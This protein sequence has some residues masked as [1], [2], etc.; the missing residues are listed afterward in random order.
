M[1][2]ARQD[3]VQSL[4]PTSGTRGAREEAAATR[5]EGRK[6]I[7]PE[8]RR[9]KALYVEWHTQLARRATGLVSTQ[10][11]LLGRGLK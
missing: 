6:D 11:S 2:S 5:T 1:Y 9:A 4:E 10:L 3:S 8:A 7:S